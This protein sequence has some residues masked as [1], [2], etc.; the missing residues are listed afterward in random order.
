MSL[1]W[2]EG[3]LC[4]CVRVVPAAKPGV[5]FWLLWG[6]VE[7]ELS[8]VGSQHPSPGLAQGCV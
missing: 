1:L 6:A 4:R 2:L 7:L 3:R 5:L 8:P